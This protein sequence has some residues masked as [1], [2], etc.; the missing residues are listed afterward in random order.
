MLIS[1]LK[2]Q[3]LVVSRTFCILGWPMLSPALLTSK[4]RSR[5]PSMFSPTTK[6]AP[7]PVCVQTPLPRRLARTPSLPVPW[8]STPLS[9]LLSL[10]QPQPQPVLSQPQGCPSVPSWPPSERPVRQPRPLIV[11]QRLVVSVCNGL[12]CFSNQF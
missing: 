6:W 9:P 2:R 10:L 3:G 1:H 7:G 8:R 5:R 4:A 12:K 11:L